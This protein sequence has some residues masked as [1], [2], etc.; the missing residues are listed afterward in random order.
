MELNNEVKD[1]VSDYIERLSY[2]KDYMAELVSNS[3]NV[4]VFIRPFVTLSRRMKLYKINKID[5][6]LIDT[7]SCSVNGSDC[8]KRV[9]EFIKQNPIRSK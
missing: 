8:K 4:N 7:V 2:E 3:F 5:S 6:G 9:K 1:E